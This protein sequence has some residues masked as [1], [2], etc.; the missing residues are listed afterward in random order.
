MIESVGIGWSKQLSEQDLS[1]EVFADFFDVVDAGVDEEGKRLP[2]C[3][4]GST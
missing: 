4:E 3:S 1:F 2:F